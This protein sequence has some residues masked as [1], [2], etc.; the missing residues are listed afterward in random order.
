MSLLSDIIGGG[1]QY[2]NT[3]D[4]IDMIRS[5][6]DKVFD[7]TDKVAGQSKAA[8]EFKPYTVTQGGTTTGFSSQGMTQQLNPQMQAVMDQLQS[9]ARQQAGTVGNVT[10]EQLMQQMSAL[11]QPQQ[12]EQDLA[13]EN[14]LAAQGRLGISS[15]QYGG[16]TPEQMILARAREQ[17][18]SQDAYNAISGAR[19]LQA[20]DVSNI[21]GMLDVANMG[22]QQ[23]T[24]ALNPALSAMQYGAPA[25][26]ML[27]SKIYSNLGQQAVAG[28]PSM[29]NAETNLKQAQMANLLSALGIGSQAVSGGSN[30][31]GGGGGASLL[32]GIIGS[33]NDYIGAGLGSLFG[34]VFGATDDQFANYGGGTDIYSDQGS[35]FGDAA[36]EADYEDFLERLEGSGVNTPA[37]T[38]GG[39]I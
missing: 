36:V 11:R 6:P 10:P 7:M 1:A 31:S 17:Q 2:L 5:Y 30:A 22:T 14:R 12:Q 19:A 39:G 28:L 20:Q 23:A 18:A 33:A 13:L 29:M 16:G 8:G 34:S 24:A 26:A 37:T 4:T 32:Q 27:Q 21:G 9:Q 15:N 25:Q 38:T 3:E 35:A